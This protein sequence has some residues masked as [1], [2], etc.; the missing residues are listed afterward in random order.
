MKKKIIPIILLGLL[1][2]QPFSVKNVNATV[3]NNTPDSIPALVLNSEILN[4]GA[5]TNRVVIKS[6][7]VTIVS[8]EYRGIVQLGTTTTTNFGWTDPKTGI[9]FGYSVAN[10]KTGNYRQYWT[11]KKSTVKYD[12]VNPIGVVLEKD[13]VSS[14]TISGWEYEESY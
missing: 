8:R 12:V 1:I 7:S 9:T 6:S 3:I 5:T 11:V 10:S 14:A 13:V 4:R 2:I